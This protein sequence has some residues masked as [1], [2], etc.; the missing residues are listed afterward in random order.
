VTRDDKNVLA[1]LATD[2]HPTQT[3]NWRLQARQGEAVEDRPVSPATF[4]CP[5]LRARRQTCG[6][7]R[8]ASS[9]SPFT[10]EIKRLTA[11]QKIGFPQFVEQ[12]IIRALY[13]AVED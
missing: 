6:P 11:R 9:T 8:Q 1:L 5:S 2:R 7:S 4:L 13:Q 10:K 12:A 3:A